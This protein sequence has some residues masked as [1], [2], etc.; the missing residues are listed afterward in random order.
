MVLRKF[1][2]HTHG[3]KTTEIAT[4]GST[5]GTFEHEVLT[6]AISNAAV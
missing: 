5:A 1:K 6:A 3:Y 4:F 2:E